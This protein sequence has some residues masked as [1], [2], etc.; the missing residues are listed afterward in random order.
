M[1][2]LIE[3][4]GRARSAGHRR[5]RFVRRPRGCSRLLLS[6]RGWRESSELQHRR[7][8][9]ASPHAR[10]AC[11]PAMSRLGLPGRYPAKN[12]PTSE[13]MSVA[14]I[15]QTP[16]AMNVPRSALGCATVKTMASASDERMSEIARAATAPARIEPQLT[17][18]PASGSA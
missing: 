3:R 15:E 11:A 13:P 16:S 6:W 12:P 10:N 5:A 4:H 17:R 1:R 14:M 7:D 18:R 2:V 9:N 8:R